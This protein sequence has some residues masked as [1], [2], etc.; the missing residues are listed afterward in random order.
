MICSQAV[1]ATTPFFTAFFTLVMLRERETNLVY[2]SLLPVV[3]GMPMPRPLCKLILPCSPCWAAHHCCNLVL[4]LF[5]SGA[6]IAM[7]T[8]AEPSFNLV[9]FGAAVG[10]TALRAFKSVLQVCS[11]HLLPPPC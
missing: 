4:T 2:T 6:G 8:G 1:G 3:V 7:A 10:A 11:M 5:W 9:G